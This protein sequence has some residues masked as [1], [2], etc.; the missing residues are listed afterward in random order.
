MGR[1]LTLSAFALLAIGVIA[2]T[3]PSFIDWQSY[4]EPIEQAA[5]DAVGRD[6]KISGSVGFTILPYPSV[7]LGGVTVANRTDG[8]SSNFL[9][10]DTLSA[11]L[12]LAPLLRGALQIETFEIAGADL[13]LERSADTVNWAFSRNSE[14]GG[15]GGG[16]IEALLIKAIR[17][18]S[19][20]DFSAKDVKVSY[21]DTV[22]GQTFNWE[23]QHGQASLASTNGPFEAEGRIILG[24]EAFFVTGKTGTMR[25]DH[26]RPVFI[27]AMTAD[28]LSFKFD[29]SADRSTGA[30]V[31]HGRTEIIAPKA[32]QLAIPFA[33]ITGTGARTW[34]GTSSLELPAKLVGQ[35]AL[36]V[37]S[38]KGAELEIEIGTA[39][40][41]GEIDL[42]I[43]QA[44]TGAVRIVS[45]TLNLDELAGALSHSAAGTADRPD[46]PDIDVEI[47]VEAASATLRETR[48][49]D[50]N[51][52]VRLL[53]SG[54][55]LGSFKAILPGQT[56]TVYA[57]KDAS[58]NRG[59]LTLETSD[60]RGFLTWM[61]ADLEGSR[62]RSFRTLSLTGDVITS[63]KDIKLTGIKAALD[64]VRVEGALVRSR[65]ERPSI[66]ANL[67]VLGLDLERFGTGN[68]VETWLDYM[69][70]F[71]INAILKLRQFTG[72]DLKR[73]SV[74]VKAQMVRGALTVEDVQVYGTPDLR[75]RGKLSRDSGG[76]LTGK[77]RIDAKNLALCSLIEKRSGVTLPGCAA[78]PMF[79]ARAKFDVAG[80]KASGDVVTTAKGLAFEGSLGGAQSTFAET[81]NLS[82][83]GKGE[84]DKVSYKIKGDA[85]DSAGETRVVAKLEAEAPQLGALLET[86]NA[87]SP[88][89]KTLSELIEN[90]AGVKLGID[91]AVRPGGTTFENMAL[92]IGSASLAGSG[93]VARND[94]GQ[95]FDLELSGQNLALLA[96]HGTDRWS[97]K[98]LDFTMPK[99]T[100][101]VMALSLKDT[102]L[103]GVAIPTARLKAQVKSG[104]LSLDLGEVVTLG[105]TWEGDIELREGKGGLIA[106]AKGKARGVNLEEFLD[107]SLGAR[108]LTGKGDMTFAVSA[109]GRSWKSL[110]ENSAGML[111]LKASNGTARGF[112]LPGFSA[113]LR[114]ASGELGARLV[115]EGALS[116]G[117]TKYTNLEA[118][119]TLADGKLR[120]I[121]LTGALEGGSLTGEG[122]IDLASLSVKGRT[123]IDLADHEGLPN[124]R[125]ALSGP[126]KRPQIAWDAEELVL[127]FTEAWL[128][129]G[130]TTQMPDLPGSDSSSVTA[131]ELKDLS[132]PDGP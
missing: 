41:L 58:R 98:T 92:Q 26:P 14:N 90:K 15:A 77:M 71:D 63:D 132:T 105:G 131:E 87:A 7:D 88:W 30:L 24:G 85:S 111:D 18:I 13:R 61:G 36:S 44:V 93:S 107:V 116:S 113:G 21:A 22:S 101:G 37:G 83:D 69:S 51:F 86:F 96:P 45:K 82:F 95:I 117:A 114:E 40:G 108:G 100:S 121:S 46:G 47:A 64:G 70:A 119:M 110:I 10:L 27:D 52:A 72:F 23:V 57:L 91:L 11:K 19:I 53:G 50:V 5:S 29:G 59:A 16:R 73:R 62:T 80:G 35:M 56:R 74:D 94:S 1:F 34:A 97:T 8:I 115:V 109:D 122:E 130:Q 3:I 125:S 103:S 66:G 79:K 99:K 60:A 12:A 126:L 43:A 120:A 6:V 32:H 127:K 128:L 4:R 55:A 67:E 118:E 49:E 84:V 129:A 106:S 81:F 75:F 17:D 76:L 2:A 20:K 89:S 124:F 123:V 31:V 25:P 54:P 48:V 33:A 42:K 112:D 9:T 38:V 78:N 39:K 102:V 104:G 28:G 68:N 65:A